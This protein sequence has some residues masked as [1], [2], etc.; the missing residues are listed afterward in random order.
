MLDVILTI[1]SIIGIILL[2]L[3]GIV[4]AI[5]LILL[6]FPIT[7]KAE[8]VK[9][10]EV[11][12]LEAK[13]DWLFRLIRVRFRYPEPGNIVVKVLWITVFD[14]KGE[15]TPKKTSDVSSNED[16]GVSA[17][18]EAEPEGNGQRE[19][20]I[21]SGTQGSSRESAVISHEAQDT[22]AEREMEGKPGNFRKI[23]DK[24]A[25]KVE[26]IK[27]KILNICDKIKHI[28]ENIKFY[29]DLLQEEQTRELI[30]HLGR[31]LKKI[32]LSIRPRKISADIVFGASSPDTTGY[33][34][35]AY[36]IL[37]PCLGKKVRF[38]PDF[39]NEVFKGEFS[40]A[41]H[42]ILF[43]LLLHAGIFAVDKKLWLLIEKVKNFRVK[44]D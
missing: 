12:R 13:A 30:R 33:C 9:D 25:D 31:R 36:G 41:G 5:L 26:K 21:A 18:A 19:K 35:A 43:P 22:D 6:F 3:L 38:H 8:G 15:K 20:K 34:M 29:K 32:I 14:S 7:Y 17:D 28:W 27:F 11:F 40:L 37:S 44:S 39:E 2:V 42:I 10:S 4:L 24:I 1:L 16:V 23:A